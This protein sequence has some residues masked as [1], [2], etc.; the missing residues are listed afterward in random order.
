[1]KILIFGGTAEAHRLSDSLCKLSVPHTVSVATEYGEQILQ[2]GSKDS[3]TKI[4]RII[5][6]RLDKDAIGRLIEDE[7]YDLIIDATHPYA[8]EISANIQQA[9][10]EITDGCVIEQKDRDDHDT[11]VIKYIRVERP[12]EELTYKSLY[13]YESNEL[14]AKALISSEG[15]ILLTTGSKELAIYTEALGPENA[16]RLYVRIIPGRESMELCERAGIKPSHIIA[17]QG[18]FGMEL[19]KALIHQY[20]IRHLVTKESGVTGG[21][22]EKY[23]AAAECGI[24]FHVIKRPAEAGDIRTY[25]PDEVI[26]MITSGYDIDIGTKH[27]VDICLA[28]IGMGADRCMTAEA[29]KAICDADIILGSARLITAAKDLIGSVCDTGDSSRTEHDAY[30]DAADH[31]KEYKAI[32]TPEDIVGYTEELADRPKCYGAYADREISVAVLFSGDSGFNSGCR[33]VY[34]ALKKRWASNPDRVSIRIVPG[35]SSVAYLA[36]KT[37]RP[38]DDA[39]ICSMHG[40]GIESIYRT[41]SHVRINSDTYALTSEYADVI[42]LAK[43]L[44]DAGMGGCEIT[45]GLDLSGADEKLICKTAEEYCAEG[46]A[47]IKDSDNAMSDRHYSLCTCY[48]HNPAPDEKAVTAGLPASGFIRGRVPMTKEEVRTVSLDKLR[49]KPHSRMLDLGCGTG[50]V[51]VEAGRL[52]P[53]GIVYAID[54]NE[55]AIELTLANAL[56]YRLSNVIVYHGEITDILKNGLKDDRITHAFIGGSK[57]RLKEILD[58]LN[59]INPHMR[60]V[61]NAITDSTR[62]SLKEWMTMNATSDGE[63]IRIQ[64]ERGSSDPFRGDM[65]QENAVYVYSFTLG[66]GPQMKHS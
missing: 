62:E 8:T 3:D 41:A 11:D 21:Y 25:S 30:G 1:M 24:E 52:M 50:S 47:C 31:G 49:L 10:G 22:D 18:P 42:G 15:N 29:Y 37:G 13:Q 38:Y 48:I 63:V 9:I 7:G 26:R 14:A 36:S 39:Y 51:S 58:E 64:V 53:D 4:R 61:V 32:Y 44:T 57:C 27:N 60:V 46:D 40:K 54:K 16:D 35:I 33:G 12:A 56:K 6:G 2:D 5:R 17:M 23:M 19:N 65:K 59:R 28:G 55:E 45:A 20:D 34:E 66:S 43:I